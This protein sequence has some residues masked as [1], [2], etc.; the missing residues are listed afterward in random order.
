MAFDLKLAKLAYGAL[1]EVLQFCVGFLGF[2][3]GRCVEKCRHGYRAGARESVGYNIV[4]ALDERELRVEL[5]N[6]VQM[7]ALPRGGFIRALGR[8]IYQGSMIREDCEWTP[9]ENS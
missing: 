6:V 8:G 7:S 9:I 4:L 1:G 3:D 2:L 5:E